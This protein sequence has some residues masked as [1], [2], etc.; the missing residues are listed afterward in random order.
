MLSQVA[1]RDRNTARLGEFFDHYCE[2]LHTLRALR[3]SGG[4]SG[5]RCASPIHG[6]PV[7]GCR[8]T[9]ED[10]ELSS[11]AL[12]SL[13]GDGRKP[14]P[15][16]APSPS[17]QSE[18]TR[19]LA[20]D[21]RQKE[22]SLQVLENLLSERDDELR[23][24]EQAHT[25]LSR[26]ATRLEHRNAELQSQLERVKE[27][28]QTKNSDYNVLL[29]DV[30]NKGYVLAECAEV[31]SAPTFELPLRQR[32][33]RRIH[34]A[35]LTCLASGPQVAPLPRSLSVAGT[36]DGIVKLLD[37]ETG[38]PH[39]QL[40]VSRELARTVAVD[41]TRS[42]LL[43]AASSDYAVRLLDLHAQKLRH[44]LRGHLGALSSCGFMQ[45]GKQAFTASVDRSVK[46]WDLERGQTQRS[47]TTGSGVTGAAAHIRSGILVAVHADGTASLWD[48]RAG[49]S[50]SVTAPVHRNRS[51]V[52]V[53][54]A[55]D[56]R[57]IVSQGDD[58]TVC[59]TSLDSM[60]ILHVLEGLGPV[61]GPSPPTYSPDG[62]HVMARGMDKVCCW[63]ATTGEL[64]CEHETP[65]PSCVSWEHS[66]ALTAHRNG[67]VLC[68]GDPPS[69]A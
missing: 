21:L 55:P 15:P 53:H 35:E 43:L 8:S 38:R 28:L 26:H 22:Q 56:G 40:Y 12:A 7:M 1:E 32:V 39:A 11:E 34:D 67:A 48:P 45:D 58:G 61:T 59:I 47:V 44:T 18:V 20:A 14:P 3:G 60:R 17:A 4:G 10:Q 37:G 62:S 69:T 64:V 41:L 30:Q 27:Q 5:S 36:A 42:G 66:C 16:A 23:E 31:R 33:S 25:E 49:D 50:M 24:K 51:V 63:H 13:P 68:W 46:L 65:G 52:G 19:R 57:A 2:C 29:A 54:V 6:S 9:Q